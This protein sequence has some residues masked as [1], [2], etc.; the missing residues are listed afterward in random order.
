MRLQPRPDGGTRLIY[1][2]TVVR[3]RMW[4]AFLAML[5]RPGKQ[6]LQSLKAHVEG[7]P[8]DSLF[9]VSAKRME[10]ARKAPQQCHCA[11]P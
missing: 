11:E 5:G 7:S 8:D 3:P 4:M 10:A 1:S 2:S 9:G 6:H